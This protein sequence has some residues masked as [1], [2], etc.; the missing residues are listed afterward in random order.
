MSKA[1]IEM[2]KESIKLYEDSQFRLEAEILSL[3]KRTRV[4]ERNLFY[5]KNLKQKF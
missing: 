1:P 3:Q 5:V 4:A 2:V